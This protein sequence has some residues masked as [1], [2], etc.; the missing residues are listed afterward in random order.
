MH[1]SWLQHCW[2]CECFQHNS[3]V[4]KDYLF[5]PKG[6]FHRWRHEFVLK[7]GH[8]CSWIVTYISNL[9]P[10]WKSHLLEWLFGA[11]GLKTT[12]PTMPIGVHSLMN[13]FVSGLQM[14]LVLP[15]QVKTQSGGYLGQSPAWDQVLAGYP[16]NLD[17]TSE[18]ECTVSDRGAGWVGHLNS[19]GRSRVLHLRATFPVLDML[20]R[21]GGV[22]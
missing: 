8:I 3:D 14:S 15:Q 12:T 7:V 9:V 5:S 19:V 2:G 17:E 10:S 11:W 22:N 16:H 18:K 1:Y 6:A 21:S 20:F 4:K 13:E